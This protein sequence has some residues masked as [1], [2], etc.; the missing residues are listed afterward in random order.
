MCPILSLLR[1]LIQD[2]ASWTRQGVGGLQSVV[3]YALP[4]L[5]GAIDPVPLGGL[6]GEQI[7]LVP[8]RVE[9]LT[10]RVKAWVSCVAS[11]RKTAKLPSFSTA[12]PLVMGR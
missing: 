1:L 10:E 9:R 8:E 12:F 7:Y 2:I 6:V 3:L 4:E 11:L 5:D